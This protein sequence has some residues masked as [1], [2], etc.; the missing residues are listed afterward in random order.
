MR[1]ATIVLSI[2]LCIAPTKQ[3]AS[4][5][6]FPTRTIDELIAQ[7]LPHATVG[8]MVTDAH[9]GQILY[10]R[11]ANKLLSPASNTKLFT[12]AA[13]L[14]YLGPNDRYLTTLSKEHNNYYLTF[15]GSPSLTSVNLK[16]ILSHLPSRISG[17]I[18]LDTTLF[19]PPYYAGGA[20]YDDLGWY[21]NAPSTAVMLDGNAVAYDVITAPTLGKPIQMKPQGPNEALKL[22]NDVLTVNKEQ[23]RT[24]CALNI[25]IQP[26]NTLR[27][28]GCLS[29]D[30]SPRKM[31]FAIPNPTLYAMQ[32]I[33][34]TLKERNIR[35]SGKI[36]EGKTPAKTKRLVTFQSDPLVNLVT[37]MLEESDNLY[38]DSLTKRL[39]NL[40]T[41]Q[42]TYKQ[43]SY[44]IKKILSDHSHIKMQ[45]LELAEGAGT[46]YNLV[47][48]EQLVI[49][50]T[51]LFEDKQMRTIFFNAL[52]HMGSTGTLKDRL[53][54]TDLVNRVLAKTGSMHDISALSGYLVM[55]SGKILIFSIIS[56]GVNGRPANKAK[57]LEDKILQAIFARMSKEDASSHV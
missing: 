14:Y 16:Q 20:S 32:I 10:E 5:A 7:A 43:G 31:Q 29:A 18:V 53:K 52:P 49:F 54:N 56:N 13:A 27:L 37:H 22:I 23:E 4:S 35:L 57:A 8:I 34:N 39:A 33:K 1:H 42:G 9:S 50:L 28:Y 19:S 24:H 47:T 21:Y 55:P 38:A 3:F 45:Q 40:L 12:A 17:N 2:G 36:I 11:N 15:S 6:T 25:D 41:G 48:P 30:E 46:R 26:N 44:A 51:D